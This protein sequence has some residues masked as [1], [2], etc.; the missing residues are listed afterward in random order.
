MHIFHPNILFLQY[1]IDFPSPHQP[2]D[3]KLPRT[4]NRLAFLKVQL[5]GVAVGRV[6]T[7]VSTKI[8]LSV[9]NGRRGRGC[10]R[11]RVRV[12]VVVLLRDYARGGE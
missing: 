2:I 3:M 5:A 12:V 6:L 11:S 10:R 8:R 9:K 1:V 4:Q 7:R